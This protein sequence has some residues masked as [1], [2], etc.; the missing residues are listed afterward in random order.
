MGS[1][2]ELLVLGLLFL[3]VALLSTLATPRRQESADP[4]PSSFHSTQWGTRALHDLLGRL[5]MKTGRRLTPFADADSLSGTLVLLDPSEG[6]SPAELHS[7]AQWVRAGGTLI[8]VAG[9]RDDVA[10]TLGLQLRDL[11]GDTLRTWGSEN[12]MRPAVPVRHAWTAGVVRVDGFRRT[13]APRSPA[14]AR[15]GAARL[16]AVGE[17]PVAAT[18]PLGRGRV[19]A[20]SDPR[21]LVN[22]TLR[23]SGAAPVFA[24]AAAELAQGGR[25]VYFDEYH[26]GYRGGGSAVAGTLRFLRDRPWGHA[27]LQ[28]FAAALGLLLL[29]GRRFGAPLA[30]APALRRSPL[31]HVEALAGAYRQGGARR[32]A[33][34]LLL[35]GLARRMG[36]RP[37]REGAGERE[38]LEKLTSF[39]SAGPAA[40]ALREE[41][42]KG[43]AADLVALSRDVDRL[44]EEAKRT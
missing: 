13:F 14:L 22:D 5:K 40:A 21:P 10:D 42:K 11:E 12:V 25:T 28:W 8:Y 31:E 9:R 19:V 33:R 16:L 26:H 38:T 3:V 44:L 35:A 30:P 39:A 2:R 17:R 18:F 29:A 6:V 27:A 43:D 4:R 15:A 24:R 36:R 1:R 37:P 32:T 7:L 34:R 23:G 20:W 41:W